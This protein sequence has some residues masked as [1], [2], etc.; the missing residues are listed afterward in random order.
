MS[1]TSIKV[2]DQ[3]SRVELGRKSVQSFR[4]DSTQPIELSRIGLRKINNS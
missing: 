2:T 3:L 1:K 4:S